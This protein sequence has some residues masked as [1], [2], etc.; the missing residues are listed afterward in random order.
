MSLKFSAVELVRLSQY[1]S[2]VEIMSGVEH[3]TL[4]P[5]NKYFNLSDILHCV[6]RWKPLKFASMPNIVLLTKWERL[7]L[8]SKMKIFP[9]PELVKGEGV[10]YQQWLMNHSVDNPLPEDCVYDWQGVSM[11]VFRDGSLWYPIKDDAEWYVVHSNHNSDIN[12]DK[13]KGD[14]LDENIITKSIDFI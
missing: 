6:L 8:K 10:P 13:N 11:D 9:S 7:D 5:Q 3:G 4:L 12:F 1:P 2:G 14:R